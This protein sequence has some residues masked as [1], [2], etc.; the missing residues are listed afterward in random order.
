MAVDT[1]DENLALAYPSLFRTQTVYSQWLDGVL[2]PLRAVENKS[3]E[4]PSR[5]PGWDGGRWMPFSNGGV[6]FD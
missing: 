1:V 5:N 2:V 4:K 3:K 6:F